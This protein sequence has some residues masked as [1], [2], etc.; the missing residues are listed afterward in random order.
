MLLINPTIAKPQNQQRNTTM[1]FRKYNSVENS[2]QNDFISAIIEQGFGDLDYVVQEKIHGANLSFI[3]DGQNILSAKR[4]ELILDNEAF[5]NAKLVQEKYTDKIFNLFKEFSQSF[6]TKTLTIF[7]ELFGGGYP[8]PDIPKDDHAKLVQRGIYYSPT[9]D[10][11]A[12]DIL[13]NNDKYL[14]VETASGLFEKFGFVYAKTLFKGTLKDCLAF[15]NEF[16]T[17]IPA[18]YGLPQLDGN[19]CEGVV[20]R[21]L[22]PSFIRGGSRVLIKNKNEKWAENNNFIDKLILSKLLHEGEV[23]SEEASFLCEEI[24]KLITQNRLTNLIS[25][26]SEV[27]PKK[28]LGK[29]LGLYNKDALTDFFKT[30]KDRYD[31]LEKHESKAVNKFLNKHAGQLINDYFEP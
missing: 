29:I 23:L 13:L 7:G 26:I 16:K 15:S 22:Q 9:N 21:P 27:N 11:F 2:Y 30:H 31:S 10:F 12:F 20:V 25:K 1:E 14:D 5:F 8:H 28:D 3:T 17:T 6:D 24:Y 18:E 4:T 19:I